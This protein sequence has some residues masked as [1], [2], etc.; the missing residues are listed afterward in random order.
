[1]SI[2]LCLVIK[3]VGEPHVASNLNTSRVR[4]ALEQLNYCT[5]ISYDWTLLT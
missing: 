3:S 4:S 5:V 1:M 2:I